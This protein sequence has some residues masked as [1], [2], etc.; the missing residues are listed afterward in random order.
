MKKLKLKK[1]SNQHAEEEKA[2]IKTY[3][4]CLGGILEYL[5][6]SGPLGWLASL[7][8]DKRSRWHTQSSLTG[9]QVV[10][11][12]LETPISLLDVY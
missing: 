8:R 1:N 3:T 11:V 6:I 12:D 5:L 9:K 4:G 7:L 2:T 10:H